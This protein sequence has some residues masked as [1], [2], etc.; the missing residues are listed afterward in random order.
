VGDELSSVDESVSVGE[1]GGSD[2]EAGRVGRRRRR[3]EISVSSSEEFPES[4]KRLLVLRVRSGVEVEGCRDRVDRREQKNVV[5]VKKKVEGRR[6]RQPTLRGEQFRQDQ[7]IFVA[8]KW[9][10]VS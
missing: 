1:G 6:V 9:E 4:C 8:Q 5:F 10:P 7:S 3:V 2:G